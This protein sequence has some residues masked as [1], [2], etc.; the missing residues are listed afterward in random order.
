[1]FSC[2][3]ALINITDKWLTAIDNDLLNGV[4]LLDLRKAFD[5]INHDILLQKLQLYKCSE[6]TMKF[7]SSYLTDRNQC[8]TFKGKL[9]E[10]LPI[11]TGVPQGSILGPLFFILF[12]ND[13]PMSITE[14]ETDMYADDS[15][16]TAVAKTVPELNDKLDTD[17]DNVDGWCG[18]NGMA[19]NVPKTKSMLVTTWQ[20]RASLP[21]NEKE[22]CVKLKG[23]ALQ[24]VKTDVLLGTTINENLDWGQHIDNVVNKINSKLAL[25]RGIKGC[26]PLAARKLFF[27][28]HILPHLDYCSSIWGC[29]PHIEKL[30]LV[31]KRAAR[32]ILDIKGKN[33]RAP[34]NRSHLLFARLGWMNIM[35]RVQFRKAT[36]VYKSLNSL[37]P[38]YLTKM[39][40]PVSN[41]TRSQSR[42]DV[43]VSPGK[44]KTIYENGFRHSSSHIWNNIS[45]NT[46]SCNTINSFKTNYVK[47]LFKSGK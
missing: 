47:E 32:T 19:P 40:T 28:T 6:N 37:A 10:K 41:N 17:M 36:M 22:L 39:F 21:D 25:L 42:K 12:I 38:E 7:F 13:L 5:L 26:L 34:E 33:I 9:S 30:L 46:R 11:T 27:N 4:V 18:E 20:K 45:T 29:S 23:Q 2:E 35:D 8:T 3:T 24:N 31:Q 44:H 16:M 15:S 14:S 43:L 1:M